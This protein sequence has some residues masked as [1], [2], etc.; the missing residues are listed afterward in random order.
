MLEADWWKHSAILGGDAQKKIYY[1]KDA[2]M[3]GLGTS[4][5]CLVQ[6]ICP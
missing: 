4:L 6:D 3:L 5:F 2:I 1:S